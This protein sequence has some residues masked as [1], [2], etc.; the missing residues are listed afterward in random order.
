MTTALIIYSILVVLAALLG[1]AI[2]KVGGDADDY[3]TGS[4]EP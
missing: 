2:C 3:E 4:D 1:C